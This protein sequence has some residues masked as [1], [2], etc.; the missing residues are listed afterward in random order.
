[1]KSVDEVIEV[2]APIAEVWSRWAE[3][4]RLPEF[5][6]G[7]TSVRRVGDD[8]LEWRAAIDG[9][10]VGWT[11]RITGWEPGRL[12]AWS[13]EE[14]TEEA[15]GRVELTEAGAGR[16]RVHVVIDW[17]SAGMVE[18][19]LARLREQVEGPAS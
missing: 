4:E 19:S 1:M 14:G 18:V 15:G 2:G 3:V 9:E 17:P 5:M 11:S 6:E 13:S 16:T 10:D 7:I 12:F 8:R